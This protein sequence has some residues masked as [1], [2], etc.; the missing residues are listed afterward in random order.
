MDSA[1]SQRLV[2]YPFVLVFYFLTLLVCIMV[3]M[4]TG[5]VDGFLL[6]ACSN[7][8]FYFTNFLPGFAELLLFLLVLFWIRIREFKIVWRKCRAGLWKTLFCLQIVKF[9]SSYY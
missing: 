6:H 4:F 1:G 8:P 9:F 3:F 5:V 7:F 2:A